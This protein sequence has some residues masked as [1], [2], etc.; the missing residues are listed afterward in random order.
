MSENNIP[1]GF[2]NARAIPGTEQFGSSDNGAQISFQVDMFEIKRQATTILAFAGKAKDI[3]VDRLK[4]A[5]WDG[6]AAGLT[7]LGS[8]EFQ[9]EVKYETYNGKEQ[10]RVEIKTSAFAFKKPLG[11]TEKRVFMAEI[12]ALAKTLGGTNGA[13]APASY[14]KDWDA[15]DKPDM[16][17]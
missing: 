4:A 17:L 14:P 1:A 7:G 9:V 11:E 15:A 2:Y 10:M 6:N 5:G 8:K 3:S 13:A 12:A 16:D